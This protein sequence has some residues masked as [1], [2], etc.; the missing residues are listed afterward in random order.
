MVEP[1][2][3]SKPEPPTPDET[4]T[5]GQSVSLSEAKIISAITAYL[6]I[7]PNGAVVD[8]IVSYIKIMCPFVTQGT[9]NHV[10]Q[11]YS[12]VF[13][14]KKF[15]KGISTE[16]RWCYAMFERVKNEWK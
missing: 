1:P 4:L 3:P 11:K 7:H 12:D 2:L 15:G 8:H 13:M 5:S 16:F 6:I 10:L 9:V 14:K